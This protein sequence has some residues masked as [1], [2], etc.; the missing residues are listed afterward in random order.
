MRFWLLVISGKWAYGPMHVTQEPQVPPGSM[1]LWAYGPMGP[2]A[3]GPM[4]GP[5]AHMG[6]WAYGPMGLWAYGPM[7]SWAHGRTIL[8]LNACL[9]TPQQHFDLERRV[10]VSRR[11]T[12]RE[13][14][15]NGPPWVPWAHG[16]PPGPL[17]P[18]VPPWQPGSLGPMGPPGP[19]GLGT[20]GWGPWSG[21]VVIVVV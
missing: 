9:R 5:W 7:G 10:S 11:V 3:H 16:S 12:L 18:W 15:D 13:S 4:H 1:G 19:L 14:W 6:P 2:W 17:G 21:V 20:Q 8:I